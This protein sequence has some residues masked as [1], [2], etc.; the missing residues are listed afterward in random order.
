[1]L[2]FLIDLSRDQLLELVRII[3]EEVPWDLNTRR[4]IQNLLHHFHKRQVKCKLQ[5][6]LAPKP[7][8]RA[9]SVSQVLNNKFS[10]MKPAEVLLPDPLWV[11]GG[12]P[13]PC[14]ASVDFVCAGE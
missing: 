14:T 5:L 8:P 12:S 3:L 1:M 6:P 7:H 9:A 13:G 2:G 4:A 11:L 10:S